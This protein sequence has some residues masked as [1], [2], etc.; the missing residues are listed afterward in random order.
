VVANVF[1][2][3]VLVGVAGSTSGGGG[4]SG[5]KSEMVQWLM[6]AETASR[7]RRLDAQELEFVSMSVA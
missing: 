6:T 5:G 7:S 4:T 2:A 3:V 1:S